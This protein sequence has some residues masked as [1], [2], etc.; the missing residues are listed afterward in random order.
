MSK[1]VARI[2]RIAIISSWVSSFGFSQLESI[3]VPKKFIFYCIFSEENDVFSEK[4]K[5]KN[6]PILERLFSTSSEALG[7]IPQAFLSPNM[8]MV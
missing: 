8:Y 2:A 4:M 5:M 7:W 3:L 6:F 1:V